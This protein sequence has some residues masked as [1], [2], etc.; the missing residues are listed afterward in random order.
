M[1]TQLN[2]IVDYFQQLQEL[3]TVGILPTSH[4]AAVENVMRD[5]EPRP[6][7]ARGEML[8]NAPESRE[9]CYV[10]PRIV[11]DAPTD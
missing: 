4:S 7:F 8:A 9:G 3:D 1:T 5:D 11:G 10:V 6:S 2:E